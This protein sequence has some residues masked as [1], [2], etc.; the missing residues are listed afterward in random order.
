MI[1]VTGSHFEKNAALKGGVAY[2]HRSSSIQF[3]DSVFLRNYAVEGGV[4]YAND[5]GTFSF[6]NCYFDSNSA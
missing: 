3:N 5:D 6:T 4:I 2:T 1:T